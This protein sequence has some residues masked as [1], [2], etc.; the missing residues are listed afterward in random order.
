[1]RHTGGT[2]VAETSTRS[3]PFERA[4]RMASCGAMMP[5]CCP[6]SSMTR[7]SRTRIRSLIRTR[8]SRRGPRMPR[9]SNPI[10]SP[11]ARLGF[12]LF[13]HLGRDV[14]EERLDAARSEIAAAAAAHRHRAVGRFTIAHYQHVRHFLDLGF[15]NLVP[16]LLL[17]RVEL[18]AQAVSLQSLDHLS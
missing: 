1:M 9:G 4:I 11:S 18:D 10:T 6:V 14:G 3:S 16:N 17:P 7:T 15:P 8:S 5:S 2:A 13:P 12:A